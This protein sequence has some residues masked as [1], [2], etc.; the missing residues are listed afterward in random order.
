[1]SYANKLAICVIENGKVLRENKVLN[2]PGNK[3]IDETFIKMPFGTEYSVRVKN[4]NTTRVLIKLDI[5]GNDVLDGNELIIE[6]NA[7]HDIKGFMKGSDAVNKFKFIE[8]T[9]KISDFRGDN[10]DD[11]IIRVEYRFEK[12]KPKIETTTIHHYDHIHH[13]YPYYQPYW[14]SPYYGAENIR[15][16]SLLFESNDSEI[17]CSTSNHPHDSFSKE[18]SIMRGMKNE[19]GITVKGSKIHESYNKVSIREED[20]E[21]QKHVMVLFLKGE[22]VSQGVKKKVDKVVRVREKITCPTC[23]TKNDSNANYCTECGTNISS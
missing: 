21:E 6:P 9:Q 23:G 22:F 8:K 17:S 18:K 7:S 1:M 10:V 19:E 20:I 15:T 2:E 13:K 3:G 16:R 4:L 5:D 12:Q 14:N 11:G